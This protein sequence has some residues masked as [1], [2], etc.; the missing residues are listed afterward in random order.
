MVIMQPR[1]TRPVSVSWCR[2]AAHA[3]A[4]TIES[5][6][7]IARAYVAAFIHLSKRWT[8]ADVI[9]YVGNQPCRAGS[10]ARNQAGRC[11]AAWLRDVTAGA[12]PSRSGDRV[13]DQGEALVGRG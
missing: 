3:P 2:F 7:V 8:L 5:K 11:S 10:D 4:A 1:L 12:F 9:R 13:A 6:T